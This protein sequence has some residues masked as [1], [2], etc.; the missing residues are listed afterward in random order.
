LVLTFLVSFDTILP[1]EDD[2]VKDKRQYELAVL[3]D[4][5]NAALGLLDGIVVDHKEG[6]KLVRLA[7]PIKK[8]TSA[9]L[10]TYYF[11][12]EPNLVPALKEQVQT[13]PDVLRSLWVTPPIPRAQRPVQPADESR[14]VVVDIKPPR[15]EAVTNEALEE[16]LEKILQ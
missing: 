10:A 2:G 6:P 3:L 7:Y 9:Y 11:F 1:M 16:T 14:N 13:K 12:A 15:T 5:E 8:H 4:N